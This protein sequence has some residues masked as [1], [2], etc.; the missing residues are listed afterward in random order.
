MGRQPPTPPG[1]LLRKRYPMGGEDGQG[2]EG[3]GSYST[4]PYMITLPCTNVTVLREYQAT[5]RVS[6]KSY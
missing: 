1:P 6:T 5:L 3:V 4:Y 2:W